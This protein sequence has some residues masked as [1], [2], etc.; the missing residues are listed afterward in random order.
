[1]AHHMSCALLRTC[2]RVLVTA[3]ALTSAVPSAAQQVRI[4]QLNDLSFGTLAVAPVDRVMTD[5]LCVYSTTAT[6]GYTIVA[7]GSGSSSAFTLASGG[8]VLPYEVQWA[9]ASGQTAGTA[10]SPNVALT[11]VTSNRSN[12]TCNGLSLTASLIVIIRSAAQGAARAGNY[13]GTLTLL[14][15]PN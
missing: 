10:L 14:V 3:V 5:N 9:F 15:A 1:M 8:N 6:G 4:R 13:T 2:S 7:R 12:P 11:G